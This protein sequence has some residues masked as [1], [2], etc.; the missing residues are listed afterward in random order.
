LKR[1]VFSLMTLAVVLSVAGAGSLAVFNDTETSTGN[2]F[3]AGTLDLKVYSKTNGWTWVD[4]P[5]TPVVISSAYWNSAIGSIIN[6]MKPGDEGTITVPIRN[7]GSVDGIAKLQLSNL[8]DFEN[9]ANEPECTAEGGTWIDGSPGTCI[10]GGTVGD[11]GPGQGEL[12]QV[13]DVVI[14]YGTVVKASGTLYDLV[15]GG[16]IELGDLNAGIVDVVTM[17]FSIDYNAVGNEIQ[18]DSVDF[19]ITF[20]LVQVGP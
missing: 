16:V 14:R 9:G 1:V 20:E 6:N 8:V 3:I 10:G 2:T 7:D 11:P 18:S 5:H 12:S 15:A 13:L 19:D 4:D 17:E